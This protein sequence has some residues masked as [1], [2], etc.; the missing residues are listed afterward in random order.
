MPFLFVIEH[1]QII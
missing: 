1:F